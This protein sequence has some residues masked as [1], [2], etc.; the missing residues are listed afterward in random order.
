MWKPLF[1]RKK[2]ER[3]KEKRNKMRLLRRVAFKKVARFFW[4]N[5][6]FAIKCSHH[7]VPTTITQNKRNIVKQVAM[8]TCS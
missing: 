8:A 5:F 3:K 4:S 1:F 6:R 2:G 7:L